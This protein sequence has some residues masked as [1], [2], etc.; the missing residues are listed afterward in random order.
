MR[1]SFDVLK[2]DLNF[3]IRG[4]SCVSGTIVDLDPSDYA[5]QIH[6]Q[7]GDLAPTRLVKVPETTRKYN[8]RG[9]KA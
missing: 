1:I 9:D 2:S 3:K 5:V 7:S 6:V 4:K 8:A